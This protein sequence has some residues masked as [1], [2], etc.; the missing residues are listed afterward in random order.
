MALFGRK[1]KDAAEKNA[2]APA[3]ESKEQNSTL[4]LIKEAME[5]A[6]EEKHNQLQQQALE[7]SKA[8]SGGNMPSADEIR[9]AQEVLA[10][11]QAAQAQGN[12][13]VGVNS[14]INTS[15]L[16]AVVSQFVQSKTQENLNL[17][18]ACI[19]NPATMVC[20]PAQIVTSKENEEKIKQGGNVKLEGP[21]HI[22]PVL[23]TDNTGKKVFPIFS[24]EDAIPDDI[25]KKSPKI[26]IPFIQCV[27]IMQG[28]KDVDAFALDPYTLNIR[29]DVN[30]KVNK[31]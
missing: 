20:I 25:K 7:A 12:A 14:P 15:S 30:I 5:E 10:R 21:V 22:N 1:K 27:N 24:S 9:K 13:K 19:Q 26:N 6:K 31:Q 17:V 18:M 8:A 4:D 3:Q 29:I 11:A 2:A 23:L 28:I 16:K